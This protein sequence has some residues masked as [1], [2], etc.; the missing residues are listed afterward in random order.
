MIKFSKAN[1]KLKKLYKVE[2]LKPWT[3]RRKIY[4]LD[5]LSGW[6]CPYA[7]EC[8]SRAI[9][10]PEGLRVKDGANCQFRCFSASQEARLVNVYKKRKDNWQ[11]LKSIKTSLGMFREMNQALARNAGIVRFHCAGDFF[12][13]RYYRAAIMLAEHRPEVLFYAYTKALRFVLDH[14]R[15]AN[16]VI[17]A[18]RGGVDD[19]LIDSHRMREAR[20]VHTVRKAE[21]LG[22]PIDNDDSHAARPDIQN[23][24][25][26]LL[27]HG[28]QPAGTEAAKAVYQLMR[29]GA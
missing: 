8:S 2:E 18:S 13:R 1:T 10:T 4:S 19:K 16:L 15:P 27:I 21:E 25:F 7:N 12:S 20:V 28:S 11:R 14:E 3:T 26:A 5:L 17:T 9:E 24:S 22:L 23:E 6:S 29:K